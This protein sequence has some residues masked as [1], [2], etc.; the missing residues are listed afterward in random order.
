MNR[1]VFRPAL[2][3]PLLL[4]LSLTACVAPGPTGKS[5]DGWSLPTFGGLGHNEEDQ[6]LAEA[7]AL[8][9]QVGNGQLTRLQAADRLDQKRLA[10]VGHNA[11]DDALFKAYRDQT[12]LLQRGQIAQADLRTRLVREIDHARRNWNAMPLPQR[13]N[14]AFT[15]FLIRIYDQAPL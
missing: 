13:P 8:A 15:R 9:G 5:G 12:V 4:A 10:L 7:N 11:I 6:L 2:A 3:A 14:A 1:S